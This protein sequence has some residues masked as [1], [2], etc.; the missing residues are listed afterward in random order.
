[1]SRRLHSRIIPTYLPG[2]R[3]GKIRSHESARDP[4]QHYIEK[5]CLTE[6]RLHDVRANATNDAK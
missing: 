5:A 4:L 1:M 3:N 2:Q 6:M